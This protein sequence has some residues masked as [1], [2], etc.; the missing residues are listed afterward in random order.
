MKTQFDF[1][2]SPVRILLQKKE[3]R[4]MFI[5]YYKLVTA[6]GLIKEKS[7]NVF[8]GVDNNKTLSF[9]SSSDK[10]GASPFDSNDVND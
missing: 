5:C 8:G 2:F 6:F 1:I 3:R 7:R 4:Y 10:C 9:C